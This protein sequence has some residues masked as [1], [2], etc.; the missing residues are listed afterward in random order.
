MICFVAAA[1]ERSGD[2][3][4]G[5]GDNNIY[6]DLGLSSRPHYYENLDELADNK[7]SVPALASGFIKMQPSSGTPAVYNSVAKK[8]M[9]CTII[10]I[11]LKL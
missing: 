2:V 9:V 6:G 4:V 5:A 10:F 11:K 3:A 7:P 1:V 8:L